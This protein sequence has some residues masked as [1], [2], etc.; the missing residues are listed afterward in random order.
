MWL[1]RS[2]CL[3]MVMIIAVDVANA[4]PECNDRDAVVASDTLAKKLFKAAVVFH[5][6]LVLKRHW[7]SRQKEVASYIQAGEKK[8]SIYTLVSPDCQAHFIKRTR[9]ND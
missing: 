9:Q 1:V 6:A 7:P 5:P 3:G 2:I 4:E 8:Y